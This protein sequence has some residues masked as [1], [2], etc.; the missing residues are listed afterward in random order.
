MGE[1]WEQTVSPVELEEEVKEGTPLVGL[2]A[3]LSRA[4]AVL[5]F[6]QRQ[7]QRLW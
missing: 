4:L 3:L 5:L 1:N 2:Q 7:A 6:R